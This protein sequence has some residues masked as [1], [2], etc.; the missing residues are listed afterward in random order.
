MG[1]AQPTPSL[2][3]FQICRGPVGGGSRRGDC[4]DGGGEA[5]ASWR[6]GERAEDMRLY[7]APSCC[8]CDTAQWRDRSWSGVDSFPPKRRSRAGGGVAG[9]T[10]I[11]SSR[12]SQPS[13]KI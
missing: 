4:V 7:R 9:V 2:R 13:Q 10:R 1:Q 3:E 6:G 5:T 12:K 8:R 11:P